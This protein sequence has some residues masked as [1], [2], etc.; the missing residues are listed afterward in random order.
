MLYDKATIHLKAGDGGDGAIA[1]RREKYEPA[2]G[3]DG[4][5]G[6][7]GG[8]VF[9]RANANIQTLLD[10]KYHKHFKAA[11]GDKG[12]GKKCFGKK[13]EDLYLDVPV[14]TV[15]REHKS[16]KP[17]YDFQK[18]GEVFLVVKGGR[19]GKGNA[20]FKN[21]VRQAP[22]FAKPGGHGQELSI[23][24]EVKLIADIGLVGL[25]NVGKSTLLSIMTNAKPKIA[26]YHFTT[27]DP[28]LGVVKGEG[29]QT[30]I[31][32]DIP[33]LIEGAS[34][35]QGLGHEF[36]RHIERT[37]AL[38]HIV[39]MSGQEARDPYEDFLT[40]QDE[41]RKYNPILE[42][43]VQLII[44]NKMDIPPSRENLKSFQSKVSLPVL[45]ISCASMEGTKQLVYTF[46]DLLKDLPKTYD[47][48]EEEIVD[49]DQFFVFDPTIEIFREGTTIYV[50]GKPVEKLSRQLI[51]TDSDSVNF[52]ETSLEKMGIMDRVRA[53]E[54]SE[55][56]T[57]NVDGFEFDWL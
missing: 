57:I 39:D 48:F 56:D 13:G 26:N 9:L 8:S 36:L 54:P 12:A 1:W 14:G 41:L 23:S 10:Y 5:D 37:R 19:G 34:S 47:S 27:L 53:L 3:P 49:V 45:P 44:A 43:K 33:G 16:Q 22:R 6:G 32:A 11:D 28:N 51:L 40:I 30:L 21:S 24:M 2:G 42:K 35:G 25:P 50:K 29:G 17:I 31:L 15:I 38:V 20:R 18:D 55:N 7:D 4:G 52:F 46:F